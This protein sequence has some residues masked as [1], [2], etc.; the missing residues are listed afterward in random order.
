M[1]ILRTALVLLL[2]SLLAACAS[3]PPKRVFPPQ[4]RLQELRVQTD[5]Q[6]AA[7]VRIQNFST[8]PMRFSRLQA[9]LTVGGVE[10]ARMDLDP[11]ITV[12]PGSIEL[13]KHVFTPSAGAKAAV[14]QAFANNR[15]VRY[16]LSGRLL[17]SDPGTD[18]AFDYPSALNPVPGLP[19]VLR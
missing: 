18:D 2:I 14:D 3:G 8:V 19:G 16:Q 9:T 11:G 5:G 15:A 13:V 1:R 7:D 17:S 4:A 12:G 10:A 6:W